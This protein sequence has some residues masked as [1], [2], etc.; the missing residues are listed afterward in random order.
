MA[1]IKAFQDLEI[2]KLSRQLHS[3][4][5]ELCSKGNLQTDYELKNQ[6]N[7]SA[8]SVMDNI[9]EGFGRGSRLE[10]IQF[11]SISKASAAELQSQLFRALDR[12]HILQEQYDV[13]NEEALKIGNKTAAFIRYLNESESKGQKFFK[14]DANAK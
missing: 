10:F 2:W 9:A 13:L 14:S 5:F 7:R 11:L 12:K 8:G 1:T 6:I 4:I 3:D